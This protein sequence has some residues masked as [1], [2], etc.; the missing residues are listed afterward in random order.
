LRGRFGLFVC[1]FE[2][3]RVRIMKS[4]LIRYRSDIVMGRI[5]PRLASLQ[6][7]ESSPDDILPPSPF[8]RV[9]PLLLLCCVLRDPF[10]KLD[11]RPVLQNNR[12]TVRSVARR[13]AT[14]LTPK[15]SASNVDSA[16]GAPLRSGLQPCSDVVESL[17]STLPES[18]TW[19]KLRLPPRRRDF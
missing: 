4:E 10:Q 14:A 12:R 18:R 19:R 9:S 2:R 8:T 17:A 11:L 13:S 7:N 16:I 6:S 5:L 15:G 1:H 3:F